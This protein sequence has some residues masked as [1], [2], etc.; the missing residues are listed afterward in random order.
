MFRLSNRVLSYFQLGVGGY[1]GS[2]IRNDRANVAVDVGAGLEVGLSPSV[3]AALSVFWVLS[4]ATLID[5]SEPKLE[6]SLYFG[7]GIGFAPGRTNP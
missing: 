2:D 7:L 6:Q 3:A 5:P 4:N 1:V